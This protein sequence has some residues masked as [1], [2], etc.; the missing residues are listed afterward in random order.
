MIFDYTRNSTTS[1]CEN[2]LTNNSLQDYEG[3]AL[4]DKENGLSNAVK[5]LDSLTYQFERHRKETSVVL[6]ELVNIYEIKN[7]L[8]KSIK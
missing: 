5:R 2:D 1:Q 4:S 6:Y 7:A 8:R 3:N